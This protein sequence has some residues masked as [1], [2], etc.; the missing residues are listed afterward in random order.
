[1]SAM[2]LGLPRAVVVAAAIANGFVGLFNLVPGLPLDGGRVL[3]AVVWSVTGDRHR[4]TVAAGWVGRAVAVGVL[5]WVLVEPLTRG[6]VPRMWSVV[7]G[8]LVGAFLWSGADTALRA[9]RAERAVGHVTV[10]GLM[11]PAVGLGPG[12]TVAD[13]ARVP[14]SHEV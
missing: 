8:A 4:G 11:V 9:G 14:T 3:E 13:V 2:P 1:G 5:A 6:A 10:Q 7:W 12:S